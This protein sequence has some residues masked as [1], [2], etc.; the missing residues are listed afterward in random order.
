MSF[1]FPAS[2]QLDIQQYARTEHISADEAALKIV[3]LGLK[4][5]RQRAARPA[6]VPKRKAAA[7]P[8]TQDE[9]ATLDEHFPGLN[10]WNDVTGEQWD[11]VLKAKQKMSREG[12]PVRDETNYDSSQLT[13]S[14]ASNLGRRQ[15]HG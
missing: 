2:V 10:P 9:L 15:R 6:P 4:A 13:W 8:L 1:D 11:R 14:V 3:Q 5:I 12:F 7:T